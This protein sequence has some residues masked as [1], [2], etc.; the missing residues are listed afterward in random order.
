[1]SYIL[2]LTLDVFVAHSSLPVAVVVLK[3][4]RNVRSK[5][6]NP[7]IMRVSENADIKLC[8]QLFVDN[9]Q[10]DLRL[11]AIFPSF[12]HNY[13]VHKLSFLNIVTEDSTV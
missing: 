2:M 13:G 9:S 1:M 6:L 4:D 10:A 12:W 5:A 8:S 7:L 11:E 3:F